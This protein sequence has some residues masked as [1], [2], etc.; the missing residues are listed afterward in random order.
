MIVL[1]SCRM[2]AFSLLLCPLLMVDL[3]CAEVTTV[4]RAQ[5]LM[6]TL[7]SITSVA[8]D[9]AAAQ[10]AAAS[11]LKEIRRLEELLSTWIPTSELSRLNEAAGREP[12]MISR[13]TMDV[14]ARSLEVA[15]LTEGGFNIAVGPAIQAWSVTEQSSI[16]SEEQLHRLLPLVELSALRLDETRRTAYLTRVGMRVDVGGIGKGFAAEI[17]RAHV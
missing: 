11:A 9:E 4:R 2:F 17:G 13:D 8:A 3:V 1:L 14:L 10:R 6:G 15:Q 12:V 16:P 5:M 7:V